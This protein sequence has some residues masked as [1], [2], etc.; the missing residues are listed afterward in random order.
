M[1]TSS[2]ISDSGRLVLVTGRFRELQGLRQVAAGLG[3]LFFFVWQLFVPL[4]PAEIRSAGPGR[5]LLGLA[6]LLAWCAVVA[7][8]VVRIDAWYRRH[9]GVVEQTRRQRRVAYL[10]AAGGVLAFIV[11]FQIE[12]AALN[13]GHS[14]PVNLFLFTFAAWIVG[15]WLY[16]GR[17]LRHYLLFAA[18]ALIFGAVSIAGLPPATFAWHLREVTLYFALVSIA[19]GLIDHAILTR[20]LSGP[21]E[22]VGDDS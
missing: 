22:P 14:V 2:G 11:P 18:L 16:I 12:T 7:A 4:T 17:E 15:Y 10:V 5:T 19:G 3:L 8:A 9:F 20:W 6:V 13:A 1:Q 21:K